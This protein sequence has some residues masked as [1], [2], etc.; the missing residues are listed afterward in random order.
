MKTFFKDLL[1]GLKTMGGIFLALA[2]CY[3]VIVMSA[4]YPVFMTAIGIIAVAWFMG[5]LNRNL[6]P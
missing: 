4:H 5:F 6:D 2:V 3:I 1:S